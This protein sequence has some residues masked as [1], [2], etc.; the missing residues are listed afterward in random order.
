MD[1]KK[2]IMAGA[3]AGVAV[4]VWTAI[5]WMALGWHRIDVDSL[6]DQYEIM[7]LLDE[8]INGKA[9]YYSP[10][11]PGEEHGEIDEETFL[12]KAKAGPV[13]HFMVYSPEGFDPFSPV[14]FITS[15]FFN[16]ISATLAAILLMLTGST[17]PSFKHRMLF[18]AG[19]GLFLA[20]NGPLANWI[21]WHF[22]TGFTL[23]NMADSVITW[24]I[25]GAVLAW[26]LPGPEADVRIS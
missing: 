11:F 14:T 10:G 18:V 26:R 25:A 12:K 9:I 3:I 21:W 13:L 22:P 5:S 1:F 7:G 2:A 6:P 16:I 24:L 23:V 8:S 4:F 15:L 19:I 17:L 20:L